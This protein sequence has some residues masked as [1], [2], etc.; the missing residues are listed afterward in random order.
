MWVL[1]EEI[2]L[3]QKKAEVYVEVILAPRKNSRDPKTTYGIVEAE[4]ALKKKYPTLVVLGCKNP[5]NLSNGYPELREKLSELKH[6]FVFEIKVEKK[7]S[8][9][10]TTS[11]TTTQ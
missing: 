9:K 8:K 10:T 6:T 2:K 3:E 1:K 4:A 11:K 7:V 5:K